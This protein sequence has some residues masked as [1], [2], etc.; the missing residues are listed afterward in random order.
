MVLFSGSISKAW[1]Y[2]TSKGIRVREFAIASS[3]TSGLALSRATFPA[4]MSNATAA[5][6]H[7]TTERLKRAIQSVT[8]ATR[9]ASDSANIG[10]SSIPYRVLYQECGHQR[11]MKIGTEP[12][13]T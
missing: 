2:A 11:G 5:R 10:S 7:G 13:A 12:Y 4:T 1:A 9:N 3:S 6:T 8:H